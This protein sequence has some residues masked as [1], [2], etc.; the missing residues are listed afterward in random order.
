MGWIPR[1]GSLWMAFPWVSAPHFVPIFS[2]DSSNYGLKFL[3]WVGGPT[4]QPGASIGSP[5]PLL[6]IL[7]N[8]IPFGYWELLA[9]LAPRT[10]WWLLPVSNPQLLH[11]SV[12][13]ADPLYI[14]DVPSY[15]WTSLFPPLPPKFHLPSASWEYFV[16][17]S[18]K[19]WSIHTLV[20]LLIEFHMVCELYLEY[21]KL[22]G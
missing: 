7:A 5:S 19:D 3:R 1:W 16:P 13:I 22:L 2:L 12:Q 17:P 11:T 8:L 4:P 18:K 6:G 9:F 10:C 21:S 20:F 15:T 14:I